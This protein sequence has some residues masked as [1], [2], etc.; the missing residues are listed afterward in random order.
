MFYG[1]SLLVLFAASLAVAQPPEKVHRIGI[2]W[3]APGPG[4]DSF[5]QGLRDLGYIEARNVAFER[6]WQA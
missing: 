5:I 2:M 3:P 4:Y 1:G 6:R